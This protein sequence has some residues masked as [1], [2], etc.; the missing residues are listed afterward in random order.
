MKFIYDGGIVVYTNRG[1]KRLFLFLKRSG[2]WLDMPKGHI[3]KNETAL[4][5]AVRETLEESGL[6]VNPDKFFKY[7][8]NY[9]YKENGEK[10]KKTLTVFL[11]KVPANSKVKVSWEHSG[12][13]WL[14]F[15]CAME[16]LKFNDQKNLIKAAN[17]YIGKEEFIEKLNN[18]YKS[19][20]SKERDWNL[21]KNFVAG[22]GP[23]NA[24]VMIIGQAP[25]RNE[26]IER[27]PFVGISGRLLDNLIKKSG[28]KR[29][30]VYIT[31]IVQFFPPKNRMPSDKEVSLCKPFLL[32]QIKIIGP[33]LIVLLGSLAAKE[34][35][36]EKSVTR[37]HGSLIENVYKYYITLH[38]AAAVRMKKNVPIIEKDFIKL[39]SILSKI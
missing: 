16:M 23:L 3:E 4:E 25:G 29:G 39:K 38:P 6:K 30:D 28:L 14:D 17:E 22:E 13:E 12:Y 9:W 31:S 34:L 33:R 26:D 8:T 20:P 32:K 36:G 10:I 24:K 35:C 37:N 15:G 11:A 19:L 1:P 5:A 18:E 2:G 7:I 21:S 27:R